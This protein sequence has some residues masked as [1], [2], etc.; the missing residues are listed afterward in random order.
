MDKPQEP[1]VK[2]AEDLLLDSR[3]PFDLEDWELQDDLEMV[4]RVA[5]SLHASGYS[6]DDK[7]VGRNLSYDAP[8]TSPAE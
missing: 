5:K 3:I 1:R 7:S 2:T 8:H 4:Q 6:R